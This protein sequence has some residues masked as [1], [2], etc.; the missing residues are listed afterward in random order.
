MRCKTGK[1]VFLASFL[2]LTAF[3]GVSA[4]KTIYV[5]DDYAK[6]QWAVSNASTG[7]RIIVREGPYSENIF[8]HKSL[9]IKSENGSDNCV[10]YSSS[11]YDSVFEV[12]A[13]YVNLIGFTVR[14]AAKGRAGIYTNADQ[15]N[16]SNNK[17]ENNYYGIYLYRSN[18]NNITGNDCSSNRW[19]GIYLHGSNGN[20]IIGNDCSYNEEGIYLEHSNSNIITGNDF[21]SNGD[22]GVCFSHSN[23]NIITGNDCSYNNEKGIYLRDDSNR[24]NIYLNNFIDNAKN[25]ASYKLSNKWNSAKKSHMFTMAKNTQTIWETIGAIIQ[26]QIQIEME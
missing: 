24:N 22:D 16:I 6:I 8:V 5:P 10:V 25:A 3:S 15:C 11:K 14:N 1:V 7:D 9:T 23:S 17:C 13:D 19:D 12:R 18:G 20:N 2:I 26:A 21:L 4:A